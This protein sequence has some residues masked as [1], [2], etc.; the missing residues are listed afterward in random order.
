MIGEYYYVKV[1]LGRWDYYCHCAQIRGELSAV[2]AYRVPCTVY[3]LP[4]TVYRLPFT[5]YRMCT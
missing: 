2:T 5:V 3:R 4:C 1:G